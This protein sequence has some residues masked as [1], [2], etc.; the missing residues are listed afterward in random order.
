MQISHFLSK[1]QQELSICPPHPNGTLE[2]G[3][4]RREILENQERNKANY[5]LKAA[6]N[7]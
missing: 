5:Q 4:G 7:L 1:A 2:M 3:L 6:Y